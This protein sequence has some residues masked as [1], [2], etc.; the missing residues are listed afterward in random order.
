MRHTY[1]ILEV[2][3]PTFEEIHDR[4]EKAGYSDAFHEE[5][6]SSE[7][8]GRSLIDMHGLAL[9]PIEPD[10]TASTT[11]DGPLAL[12]ISLEGD[13]SAR[14]YAGRKFVEPVESPTI[15]CLPDG[16]K[17]GRPSVG[18]WALMPNG[19]VAFIQTSL[20]LLLTA[21]DALKARYGDP[22]QD[23]RPG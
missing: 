15:T 6:M 14:R 17:S 10:M 13:G 2:S 7:N 4:L 11:S 22:R 1:A 12:H 19:E 5:D 20:R 16:M 8:E 9:A 18:I 21:A 3:P 23:D